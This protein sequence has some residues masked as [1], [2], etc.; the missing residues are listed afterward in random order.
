MLFRHYEAVGACFWIVNSWQRCI[1]LCLVVATVGIASAICECPGG[2][3]SFLFCDRRHCAQFTIL[4]YV[5][6]PV[7]AA[8]RA[9]TSLLMGY[10]VPGASDQHGVVQAMNLH[11]HSLPFIVT[12]KL[13]EHNW[14]L[15]GQFGLVSSL[16]F[17]D[18]WQVLL[19]SH[20]SN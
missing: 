15:C 19:H 12:D 9:T 10:T 6:L 7:M 13:K 8:E 5:D 16:L 3:V 20:R 4:C 17:D 1:V 2:L 14:L 18:F 11:L